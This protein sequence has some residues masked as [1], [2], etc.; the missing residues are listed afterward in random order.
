MKFI[1]K[2]N[3]ILKRMSKKELLEENMAVEIFINGAANYQQK[4]KELLLKKDE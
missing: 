3:N 2:Q 1:R 4:V